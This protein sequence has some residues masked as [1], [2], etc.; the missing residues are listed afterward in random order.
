VGDR[1]LCSASYRWPVR[2]FLERRD[3]RNLTKIEADS[4]RYC[5]VS[6]IDC[7]E[8]RRIASEQL[9]LFKSLGRE[10]WRRHCEAKNKCVQRLTS[11]RFYLSPCSAPSGQFPASS[12]IKPRVVINCNLCITI[13]TASRLKLPE[14]SSSY[15]HPTMLLST[16]SS[17]QAPVK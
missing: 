13:I 14:Y 10:S 4:C 9:E 16:D 12:I 15:M 6:D 8:A 5:N 11:V 3:Q 17:I 7:I 2:C 1:I